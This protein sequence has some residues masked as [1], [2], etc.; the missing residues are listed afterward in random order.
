MPD[1]DNSTPAERP[2]LTQKRAPGS[3]PAMGVPGSLPKIG[4]F[5]KPIR[6]Q[7]SPAGEGAPPSDQ[8]KSSSAK[9]VVWV[10]IVAALAVASYFAL[11]NVLSGPTDNGGEIVE[12]TATV[13][14]EDPLAMYVAEGVKLDEEASD[15]QDPLAYTSE[16]QKV[17]ETSEALFTLDDLM[18]SRYETFTRVAFYPSLSEG[19]S[20]VPEVMAEYSSNPDSYDQITLTFLNTSFSED[21]SVLDGESLSPGSDTVSSVMGETATSVEG[22]LQFNV[23]LSQPTT[24]V[25]HIAAGDIP[26][27]YLDI[28]EV[29]VLVTDTPETT[30]TPSVDVTTTPKVTTTTT[31]TPAP[32]ASVY[33]TTYSIEAQELR[34][35][36]TSNTASAGLFENDKSFNWGD[37]SDAFYFYRALNKGDGG[38]KYPKVTAKYEG[39]ILVVEVQNLQSRNVSSPA[40]TFPGARDVQ[41]LDASQSG[42]V[43]RFEFTVSS[44]KQY[45]LSFKEYMGSESLLIQIKH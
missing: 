34:D 1:L 26:I 44:Q 40:I 22:A 5:D 17:G 2:T 29:A 11:R 13:I 16:P 4:A 43:L 15:L 31:T 25:L 19:D 36:L 37:F 18:V 28:K 23:D 8:P 42:N 20:V 10:V 32:G 3:T 9:I 6:L 24:Y 21:L 41:S 30:V 14:E 45:K 39:N 12:P 35:G 7:S 33:E 38:T 27:I